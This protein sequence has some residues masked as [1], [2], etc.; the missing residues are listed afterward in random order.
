MDKIQENIIKEFGLE[1]MSQDAQNDVAAKMTESVLKRIT[2]SVLERLSEEEIAEFEKLQEAGI[3]E[4]LD[5][6]LKEK[7]SDYEQM[8]QKIIIDFKE[9]IK[10]TISGLKESL[11]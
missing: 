5:R 2:V 10:E 11:K 4:D 7:I 9:E 1:G 6:F 3:P 8:V